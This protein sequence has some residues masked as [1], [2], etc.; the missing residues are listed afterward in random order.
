MEVP[1]FLYLG[2]HNQ[3][4]LDLTVWKYEDPNATEA[5]LFKLLRKNTERIQTELA[6]ACNVQ[7]ENKVQELH[8]Q[9][10][11]LWDPHGS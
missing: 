3:R 8:T 11:T 4:L 5:D 2:L 10:A 6:A 9:V 1:A 7:L